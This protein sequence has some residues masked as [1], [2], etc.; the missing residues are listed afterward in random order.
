[1]PKQLHELNNFNTGIV[2]NADERDIEA[3]SASYSLN[4]NPVAKDGIL[5]AIN[6]DKF[7]FSSSGTFVKVLEPHNWAR[8]ESYTD[9]YD[10]LCL[11]DNFEKIS[12][13]LASSVTFIGTQGYREKLLINGVEPKMARLWSKE[14][15]RGGIVYLQF[16]PSTAI[17]ENTTTIDFAENLGISYKQET[18]KTSKNI[19][20]VLKKGDYIQLTSGVTI[21]DL[22]V[23]SGTATV[24]TSTVHGFKESQTIYIEANNP[25]YNEKVVITVDSSTTSF[26]YT[27]AN[28]DVTNLTGTVF[29]YNSIRS[30]ESNGE[31]ILLKEKIEDTIAT[32]KV[33]RGVLNSTVLPY[34]ASTQY[35]IFGN[36]F[37][38]NSTQ[39][40]SKQGWIDG[41]SNWSK[42]SGNNIKGNSSYLSNA[43]NDNTN[44]DSG[45]KIAAN[46][47]S[48]VTTWNK[49]NKTFT[50]TMPND[51]KVIERN[52]PESSKIT[53]YASIDDKINSGETFTLKHFGDG[54]Y[55]PL[56]FKEAPVDAAET[57]F[58]WYLEANLLK[59]HTFH[60]TVDT[61]TTDI[62]V[63]SLNI[64]K[65]NDWK[66]RRLS[67][68]SEGA[69]SFQQNSWQG[70]S[71]TN[72]KTSTAVSQ[73]TSGGYWEDT[74][75]HGT[76][77]AAN[78]YPY[79]SG[80]RYMRIN[81]TY[82]RQSGG[83]TGLY[84][85]TALSND[86]EDNILYLN[87]SGNQRFAKGDIIYMDNGITAAGKITFASNTLSH[88]EDDELVLTS[89]DGTEITYKF[90]A[91]DDL[92]NTGD[93]SGTDVVCQLNGLTAS[94]HT[95][96]EQFIEALN[97][98][99]G[100]GE[101]RI[102]ARTQ[103][104]AGN[105]NVIVHLYQV[106]AG[107]G[108]NVGPTS[109]DGTNINITT[110]FTGGA[111]TG[112]TKEYMKVLAVNNRALTVE[113]GYYESF[114]K[115]HY[116][117][118][119]NYIYKNFFN[120]ISQTVS[121][122]KLKKGQKYN[123]SFYAKQV[124]TAA[125]AIFNIEDKP[126]NGTGL[127]IA[128]GKNRNN[129]F[130]FD[131]AH[132]AANNNWP[133]TSVSAVPQ[134]RL[135]FS[136][137]PDENSFFTLSDTDGNKWRFIFGDSSVSN[138]QTFLAGDE[139]SQEVGSN[140]ALNG[141]FDTDSDW[142]KNL[143]WIINTSAGIAVKETATAHSILQSGILIVA[144][145]YKITFDIQVDVGTL[146]PYAGTTAGTAVS[147]TGTY[148]QYI[149]CAGTTNLKFLADGDFLGSIDNVIC[150]EIRNH[151][152]IGRSGG[153]GVND[154][155]T[156][157]TST[158][159]A[160]GGG[161]AFGTLNVTAT[162]STDMVLLTQ[163]SG[164]PFYN[165]TIDK[166]EED[167]N[168][169]MTDIGWNYIMEVGLS[170]AG[171]TTAYA[172]ALN[173]AI[174]VGCVETNAN[175]PAAIGE[176]GM[177]CRIDAANALN[178]LTLTQNVT[179]T[180]GNTHIETIN[181][182]HGDANTS[183]FGSLDGSE[184]GFSGGFNANGGLLLEV[185]GG[186]IE[187]NGTWIKPTPKPGDGFGAHK[188]DPTFQK[189]IIS[190]SELDSPNGDLKGHIS[191]SWKKY[192][193]SFEIPYNVNFVDELTGDDAGLSIT[194]V[195][196]G[197]D[198]TAIEIDLIDL[199]EDT[200][201][202]SVDNNSM[203]SNANFI[204]NQGLQ[205]LI[206][207]D[208]K[209]NQIKMIT[210]FD[211]LSLSR[212]DF[213]DIEI[214]KNL[215]NKLE[216]ISSNNNMSLILRNRAAHMGFGSASKDSLPKWI[217]YLN[218]QFFDEKLD[219]TLY[220]DNDFVPQYG[221][222]GG[223][224]LAAHMNKM[225]P[226]GE[227][228][229][230]SAVINTA[231]DITGSIYTGI[232]KIQS[233]TVTHNCNDLNRFNVSDNITVREYMDTN[234]SW[235]GRGVWIIYDIIN[236][237]SFNCI[238]YP[239]RD[240][241]E[242]ATGTKRIAFRPYYYY[243]CVRGQDR[244]FRIN[245]E[246]LLEWKDN[247][248]GLKE[249]IPNTSALKAGTIQAS[250]PLDFRV[251]S[252]CSSYNK[253]SNGRD[254][255]HIWILP[256]FG[257]TEDVRLYNMDIE[258]DAFSWN[259]SS[260]GTKSIIQSVFRSY[261]FSNISVGDHGKGSR[262]PSK[263]DD[264][265]TNAYIDNPSGYPSD[266]LETK[267]T[268]ELFDP[269]ETDNTDA[270]VGPKAFD[271]RLWIQFHHGS[272]AF[273]ENGRF[274]FCGRTSWENTKEGVQE[275]HFA[276]RTPAMTHLYSKVTR[277]TTSDSTQPKRLQY[278]AGPFY[279]YS[280]A[281]GRDHDT[282]EWKKYT[283]SKSKMQKHAI[284]NCKLDDANESDNYVERLGIV[285]NN[286]GEDQK[287]K[288]KYCEYLDSDRN[289]FPYFHMGYN[290]GWRQV[291]KQ[292][293]NLRLPKYG[294]FQ[295]ADN[296][297]DGI[298]DGTGLI[299]LNKNT[300]S[301]SVDSSVP[302]TENRKGKYGG[303]H[304]RV[305]SHCVGLICSS[306]RVWIKNAGKLITHPPGSDYAS[307][308]LS[309]GNNS[310]A[311]GAYYQHDAPEC[312][313]MKKFVAV[314]SDIHFGD[315]RQ[316]HRNQIKGIEGFDNNRMTKLKLNFNH[317]LQAGDLIYLDL[318]Y[319]TKTIGGAFDY[320]NWKGWQTSTYIAQISGDKTI[321]VPI[322]YDGNNKTMAEL[323]GKYPFIYVGG[324][325]R[326]AIRGEK[327]D[328][329]IDK[330]ADPRGE[331]EAGPGR[332]P[333]AR[334]PK[335]GGHFG[336]GMQHYHWAFDS[337]ASDYQKGD[338]F[339]DSD[340]AAGHYCPTWFSQ[341]H[342]FGPSDYE[343]TGTHGM[344]FPGFLHKVDRLSALSG[345]MFRPFTQSDETF[346]QLIVGD[347]TVTSMPCFPDAI[348]HRGSHAFEGKPFTL[349]GMT[350][351][352]NSPW[353]SGLSHTDCKKL[354]VGM[355]ITEYHTDNSPI[356]SDGAWDESRVSSGAVVQ[357][358]N[359]D[360]DE[361]M[362]SDL[363]TNLSSGTA[364][365]V[366]I[367]FGGHP[368]NQY[369]SRLFVACKT[370]GNERG[371]V[372][373]VDWNL[374][375]PDE[376]TQRPLNCTSYPTSGSGGYGSGDYNTNTTNEINTTDYVCSGVLHQYYD[377]D[378]AS[379][380]TT[381]RN[382]AG[383]H[384]IVEVFARLDEFDRR[385]VADRGIFKN[386]ND[387]ALIETAGING[388]HTS[389]Y[390]RFNFNVATK[391]GQQNKSYYRIP[392]VFHGMWISVIDRIYGFV[393]TRKIIGSWSSK[394]WTVQGSIF[395]GGNNHS[396]G[397]NHRF[398][399][400]FPFGHPP[401][402]GDRFYVWEDSAVSVASL[403]KLQ[404]HNPKD[405][406]SRQSIDMHDNIPG[407]NESPFNSGTPTRDTHM[408]EVQNTVTNIPG[409]RNETYN[410][411][412]ERRFYIRANYPPNIPSSNNPIYTNASDIRGPFATFYTGKKHFLTPGDDIEI[413]DSESDSNFDGVYEIKS[414]PSAYAFVIAQDAKEDYEN[415]KKGKFRILHQSAS[416]GRAPTSNPAW[417]NMDYPTIMGTYGGLGYENTKRFG[418]YRLANNNKRSDITV[419]GQASAGAKG[420]YTMH[421]PHLAVV[422]DLPINAIRQF[423]KGQII[424]LT[425]DMFTEYNSNHNGFDSDYGGLVNR[426]WG[427]GTVS[428]THDRYSEEE[429]VDSGSG[430]H[431]VDLKTQ[432][433]YGPNTIKSKASGRFQIYD[434]DYAT[435][436]MWVPNELAFNI[437]SWT[438]KIELTDEKWDLVI[439]SQT[440]ATKFGHLKCGLESWDRS[441]GGG[442]P[443][444][445]RTYS[446]DSGNIYSYY[447]H[448][449][450]QDSLGVTPVGIA[451]E[452]GDY[453]KKNTQY[454]YKISLMYDGYQEGPLSSSS[455]I[456]NDSKSYDEMQLKIGLTDGYSKRLTQIQLYR[457]K[458][459]TE[460][461]KH[462][463]EIS[464]DSGEGWSKD[465]NKWMF[466][467][468]D[469]GKSGAAFETRTGFSELIETLKIKY[470]VSAQIDGYLFV[471][472]CKHDKIDDASTMIFRSKPGQYSVF[473]WT[474]DF[475]NIPVKPTAIASFNGRLFVFGTNNTYKINQHDLTIEDTFEGIGCLGPNSFTITEYG[476][477][478]ADRNG[479]YMHN[480]STPVRISEAITSG[481]DTDMFSISNSSTIGSSFMRDI[482][483]QN[484]VSQESD[485]VPYVR[486]DSQK[487][488]VL[489][490]VEK[491]SALKESHP[492]ITSGGVNPITQA[493]LTT[494][495]FFYCW[496]YNL[497]K[498][499]WDLW[500][501]GEGDDLGVP[502]VGKDGKIYISIDSIVYEYTGGN[503]KRSFTWLSKKLT[504]GQS[505]QLK[506][507]N[508]IK[509]TGSELNQNLGG[510]WNDSS[511]KLILATNTG[512]ITSGSN[513]TIEQ[514]A[515][516]QKENNSGEYKLK[517]SNKTGKWIQILLENQ[518][519][520]IESIGF[521]F[522]KR[523]VK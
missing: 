390:P 449:N 120:S 403:H 382:D 204:D 206:F 442:A 475:I 212:F 31:I 473:D 53:F 101:E 512:R 478:F 465:G 28:S 103:Y 259:K 153:A 299:T 67:A 459:Y 271:T 282:T 303:K 265:R 424:A 502:F 340:R 437:N 289:T 296:D 480:G 221:G 419:N 427:Y 241:I 144:K 132:T 208:S 344:M 171:D 196:R 310:K 416:Q 291:D 483:W 246:D 71:V 287:Y 99:N 315:Y 385:Q 322:Y 453:F 329:T 477:F 184:L 513:D 292:E 286:K 443:D 499:R 412:N 231:A 312:V 29:S 156:R 210:K 81:S 392:N 66:A 235:I 501:V 167:D 140:L 107:T 209:A 472:D 467:Y 121:S 433:P 226:A 186:Y 183:M 350:I 379:S 260:V 429:N 51:F 445:L 83:G 357:R 146:T 503:T 187:E 365:S 237:N 428:G 191:T 279:G 224:Y 313:S 441:A 78:Y 264:E 245:P 436:K 267:G 114:P 23:S 117:A 261:K 104:N 232:D 369:A 409:K 448:I 225:C 411:N 129:R 326:N 94:A 370:G 137:V 362:M 248:D 19:G 507:F 389:A 233:M 193:I 17:A 413:Y 514:M 14:S 358:I 454:E 111:N 199:C 61:I 297:G 464:T 375:R 89:T 63:G 485:I 213:S 430:H 181:Y 147:A 451:N 347:A 414:I 444:Y 165:N 335:G 41:F 398:A 177:L 218:H 319:G 27:T 54:L 64:Y 194:L 490:F 222:E 468:L 328:G 142:T 327:N 118:S 98:E 244:L 162:A 203:V 141:T 60:H 84:L 130:I 305:S 332:N 95:A 387:R 217:G 307:E 202:V 457:R 220:A 116:A 510:N 404:R 175:Y 45:S 125:T 481:G 283:S 520:P 25:A 396:R 139:F 360:D 434:I 68:E 484:T 417:V 173:N 198:G 157:V 30:S 352:A 523:A 128:D 250:P 154:I 42:W 77:Q 380:S 491:K 179:G 91:D 408:Q 509:I 420:S 446:E 138:G 40:K 288:G 214:T 110:G 163:D 302:Q 180:S 314:C 395:S 290:V 159:N 195:S 205:D 311:P 254:G 170:G 22:D 123:L 243:G 219:N 324:F 372:F 496:S 334:L 489:F 461:F 176:K 257:S 356:G 38:I 278:N 135:K 62:D 511:D 48:W 349:T 505:T 200:T 393:Q 192:E 155:A 363:P 112:G 55:Y 399:V 432:Y 106:R 105:T 236:A 506:V 43:S 452:T 6:N 439:A 422:K 341:Q 37:E 455:W 431:S 500:E 35:S 113:R 321:V 331:T 330:N 172:L 9:M 56:T 124:G 238:R 266:I 18:N 482:S 333:S 359:L 515:F 11:I 388:F 342:N 143:G 32:F 79:A 497:R 394:R 39:Y 109:T 108:G 371:R 47:S 378:K 8:N 126:L 383:T 435:G 151:V 97:D 149:K 504:M 70:D 160:A 4:V 75:I 76:S 508:K 21:S 488:C 7:I 306:E 318:E 425:N 463:K 366:I 381:T 346:E 178:K 251:E 100:H 230:I 270:S 516:R 402:A 145:S 397:D 166:S 373:T 197:A 351:T 280:Q 234:M 256:T 355:P 12:P 519:E 36:R 26:R 345:K 15:K 269:L 521:I 223:G 2:L 410:T 127:V 90:D 401:E 361:F 263:D 298:I 450:K 374:L 57:G 5:E 46:T 391:H 277:Y 368:M 201:I 462:I 49:A 337:D 258:E 148:T 447:Y 50:N 119:A 469:D 440:G 294:L 493:N 354:Y 3:E 92:G 85:T 317:Y 456:W 34:T 487:N 474:T 227:Y 115:Y 164:V 320:S 384:P 304:Q 239:E 69:V 93:L 88:Y 438:K 247:E 72:N 59:N 421:E 229:Q 400:H 152:E 316:P 249:L 492:I 336:G 274:L 150:T 87:S 242:I 295:I 405:I 133:D 343:D 300:D 325:R 364:T 44:S 522:R 10:T 33:E 16:R 284:Y 281:N 301:S 58:D 174:D 86:K 406:P 466:S 24:T 136:A 415:S 255:G 216:A 102:I 339:K 308:W 476:M 253:A 517:S 272:N 418:G 386:P 276:D 169:N 479:A 407:L 52:F 275:I 20:E 460:S 189:Y 376:S 498:Q 240:N 486:F 188:E 96:A 495:S 211:N 182:T 458:G 262:Y 134:N 348:L 82:A 470:G 377:R 323:S 74:N 73:Q 309:L 1:M 190:L 494:K 185:G 215:N 13:Y 353:V 471:G 131:D 122:T 518:T 268:S 367:R 338:I 252:I 207:Y 285:R 423:K 65:V 161:S 228:E 293:C 158:I 80:D 273:K 168:L 426:Q